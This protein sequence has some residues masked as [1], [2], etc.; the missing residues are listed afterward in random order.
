MKAHLESHLKYAKKYLGVLWTEQTKIEFFGLNAKR[1]VWCKPNTAHHPKN[2]IPTVKPGW[3][4]HVTGMFLI[5]RDWER[6]DGM[7][8]E[9]RNVQRSP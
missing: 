7:E 2:T 9:W 6:S 3:Q 4:N 1:Y 5:V 8:N